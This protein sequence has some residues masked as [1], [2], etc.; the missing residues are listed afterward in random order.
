M[1]RTRL[2]HEVLHAH[3]H[4]ELETDRLM[5]DA[6]RT[7]FADA[8]LTFGPGE[9]RQVMREQFA[10]IRRSIVAEIALLPDNKDEQQE[11]EVLAGLEEEA[12]PLVQLLE[13][14]AGLAATGRAADVRESLRSALM[15]GL[16]TQFRRSVDAAVA[17]EKAETHRAEAAA[18]RALAW[19]ATLAKLVAGLAVVTGVICL[20]ILLHR[21]QRPLAALADAAEA[22]ARGNFDSRVAGIAPDGELGRVA[23][24]FNRMLDEVVRGRAALQDSHGALERA[25]AARTAELAAANETL[26]R[27]DAARRK[28]LADVSHELRTPL[29]VIRGEAEIAARGREKA[30][31]DYLQA[32]GRI[33]EEAARTARLVD[34]LLFVARS[35]AGEARTAMQ[36]VALEEVVRSAIRAAQTLGAPRGIRVVPPAP[37]RRLA[38][39][40]DPDRLR[41][42]VMILLDNA[43]GYSDPGSE[44]RIELEA[45]PSAVRLAVIDHGIGI[46]PE[47]LER[48]FERFQRGEGASRQNHEGHGLGLSLARAIARAHGGEARLESEPGKG[49]TAI[50]VLPA[51][52]PLQAVA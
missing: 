6:A 4:L 38:V 29:T 32:L 48:V 50:V 40:G 21:L 24:S 19:P 13:E 47:E 17:R 18:A 33:A 1:E 22:V 20:V 7:A 35:E 11:L 36:V 14:A 3:L 30:A 26:R 51:T 37:T 5:R 25:V 12:Q 42:L 46:A 52:L 44:V 41:Q 2:A 8:P 27:S 39:Q 31:A 34:D 9:V 43:V 10:H 16:G 15:V 28:F 49:T 23:R 45:L